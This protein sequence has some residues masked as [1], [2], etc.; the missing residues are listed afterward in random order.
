M[1]I[2]S[3]NPLITAAGLA[4]LLLMAAAP[5]MA[6][7]PLFTP[8]GLAAG[9]GTEVYDAQTLH[10][11]GAA[12]I[13]FNEDGW[14]DLFLVNGHDSSPH[15][16]QNDTDG[17]FTQVDE[18]LPVLPNVEMPG[19]IFA[20]Y[21]ND[22]DSDLFVFTD[23]EF[24]D[25][26]D[27]INPAD[28][29]LNILL[30]NKW[31]ENGN[32]II[33]GQPL[34]EEVAAAAGLDEEE[35]P[36]LGPTYTGWRTI[37]GGWLDYDRDG[38]IDLYVA[39][40]VAAHEGEEVTQ[41][42][43]Y[44]NLGNGTFENT[45]VSSG[46]QPGVDPET[47]RPT[48]AMFAGHL[49]PDL[50]PDL[51]VANVIGPPPFSAD[52]HFQNNKDGTFTDVTAN[53]P[54]IADDAA[55]AMGVAVGD[56]DL[57]GDWD[58][59][60]T[61]INGGAS[62]E[63]HGNVLYLNNGDGTFSDNSA[64]AAGVVADT[65]W[66]ANFFDA[67]HDG[68]ED[69]FVGTGGEAAYFFY[70]NDGLP[71]PTTFTDMSVASGLAI[72]RN[73]RGSALADYDNDGDQDLVVLN[74]GSRVMLFRNDTPNAGH[75]LK[76]KLEGGTGNRD[77]IGAVVKV[78]AGGKM[79]KRQISGI[80]S[81]HSQDSLV[82]HFG[83]GAETEALVVQIQWPSGITET[84]ENVPADQL[85]EVTEPEDPGFSFT[86]V[87]TSAGLGFSHGYV[88]GAG[89][90]YERIGAGIAVGDYD[91][92]DF[93]D[94]YMVRGSIG[95]NLLFHNLG[96]G[97]F[98]EVGA[99]AGVDVDNSRGAGPRFFDADGDGWLDLLVGA[100]NNAPTRL[101][102]NLG[103]G[104]FEDLTPTA[105]ISVNRSTFAS[106]F[107]D[108]DKDHDLDIAQSH[109]GTGADLCDPCDGHIWL[110]NGDNTFTEADAT[111]GVIYANGGV[112]HTFDPSFADINGDNWPD[113]L[114]VS[115]FGTTRTYINDGDGTFTETTDP[116]VITD[117]N[118]MGGE[119]VDYDGDGD[120]DW[121]VTSIFGGPENPNFAGRTGNRLYRN[122]GD[123]SFEDVTSEAGPRIGDWGWGPCFAD[124]NND[125]HF[126]I[127]HVNGWAQ[128]SFEEDLSKLFLSNGD[129]TFTQMAPLLGI[130][131]TG[132][133]RGLSCLDF[134][135]DG[136]V[137][138]LASNNE[139]EPTLFRNDG[140]N[141]K[142]FLNIS[143]RSRTPN[144][145]GIGAKVHVELDNGDM[146]DQ[147][148]RS[149]GGFVSQHPHEIHLGLD[150]ATM[151]DVIEVSWPDGIVNTYTDVAANQF[152]ELKQVY[153]SV[154]LYIPM[155]GPSAFSAR[156]KLKNLN[157]Q[158]TEGLVF[159]YEDSND[160]TQWYAIA[161]DWDTDGI[162]TAGLWDRQLGEFRLRNENSTG[163]ADVVFAFG[164]SGTRVTPVA[165]DWDGDGTDTIGTYNSSSRSFSLRNSNDAGPA[166]ISFK[167]GASGVPGSA[168]RPVMGD[169][170]GDGEDTVGLYNPS[171]GEFLLRNSNSGGAADHSFQFGP[172]GGDL[173]PI[174]GDWD[175]DGDDTIGVWDRGSGDFYLRNDNSAGPEDIT[176]R[177]GGQG[178]GIVAVAGL[179]N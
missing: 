16:F 25:L 125:G 159:N 15:L 126:D 151:A 104:T 79:M 114:L 146:H 139:Q 127:F 13:D 37:T 10:G 73:A 70:H 9:L 174:A 156:W 97:T 96:N 123:G 82:L 119:L 158:A 164:S 117:E 72:Q 110:N 81:A 34:F 179:W 32:Q 133:G 43:L 85:L 112:D 89:S 155:P 6:A 51:Y 160:G 39:H 178:P 153:D 175:G 115:D 56:I 170:D 111:T 122:L 91:N 172:A 165:G 11:L 154:G 64:P 105:G 167:F 28:G 166:D 143:L 132:Q 90:P 109:W 68:Y 107:A 38:W 17:T 161:G 33:G 8:V 62:A 66:P 162:G 131:D 54:G 46:I 78:D 141:A 150:D 41:D 93:L 116:G 168:F 14:P 58:L 121:F 3:R 136:D 138:I 26:N 102:R 19:V 152:V 148:M 76:V 134:D 23:N 86:D 95:P 176:F 45:S 24:L 42:R 59:Y 171:T 92:D 48:L 87:T 77:A 83:L 44:R 135:R 124:F 99:A 128:F 137:D 4:A 84:L 7:Q 169:W 52:F 118:G 30:K 145:D 49:D 29:P 140:G 53:S 147:E 75:W 142:N 1:I 144:T 108:I 120:L 67:D 63:P 12:W 2:Q 60:I 18:L 129:G 69:L 106:T 88:G 61:D 157:E 94:L 40:W 149:G 50:W 22:G 20:D 163:A 80:S 173:L 103:D 113:L 27:P 36:P 101:F 47:Y 65:S 71:S 100:V 5:P 98:E 130:E 55:A 177:H 74:Q 35:N 57:D 21:D 31:V